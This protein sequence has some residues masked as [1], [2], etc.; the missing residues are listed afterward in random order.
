[1]FTTALSGK[2]ITVIHSLPLITQG[3]PGRERA[4]PDDHGL[5]SAGTP[6]ENTTS[7][8]LLQLCGEEIGSC[9]VEGSDPVYTQHLPLLLALVPT[10]MGSRSKCPSLFPNLPLRKG[11]NTVYYFPDSKIINR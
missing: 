2:V 11:P 8:E 7:Q 10:D 9:A 4:S 1:M 3:A 6:L 5:G